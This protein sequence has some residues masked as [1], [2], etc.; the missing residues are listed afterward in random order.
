MDDGFSVVPTDKISEMVSVFNAA[1]N[2]IKFT[3]EVEVDGVLNFLDIKII[4]NL[5][6]SLTTNWYQK[7]TYS[8]RYLNYFSSHPVQHKR[9]VVNSLVDRAI[10]LS[11]KKFHSENLANV[12]QVLAWNCYPLDFVEINIKKD[13][14]YC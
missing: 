13:Y 11:D 9:G 5:D 4:R 12:K 10:L 3:Y 1:D 7:P 6:G 8:G 14:I 2:R